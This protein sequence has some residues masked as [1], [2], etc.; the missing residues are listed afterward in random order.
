M[1]RLSRVRGWPGHPEVGHA[2]RPVIDN[3][4]DEVDTSMPKDDRMLAVYWC[5]MWLEVLDV[6]DSPA[7]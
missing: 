1:H 7:P 4:L 2:L 6:L 3:E 5:D